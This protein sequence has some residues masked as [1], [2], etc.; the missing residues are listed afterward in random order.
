[1]RQRPAEQ[2]DC[3]T[4]AFGAAKSLESNVLDDG[5]FGADSPASYARI[6]FDD[7]TYPDTFNRQIRCSPGAL[8]RRNCARHL[9]RVSRQCSRYRAADIC[10]GATLTGLKRF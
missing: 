4:T 10:I 6:S 3:C 9:D 7:G 1:K 5:I 2:F 8:A